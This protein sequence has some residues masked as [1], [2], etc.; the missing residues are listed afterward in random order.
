MSKDPR[1]EAERLLNA[2]SD[3]I[4]GTL[5]QPSDPRAWDTLLIYCPREAVIRRLKTLTDRDKAERWAPPLDVE[6]GLT[7][8][9][10]CVV[11]GTQTVMCC[12]DCA[13]ERNG[14]KVYVCSSRECCDKHELLHP[15]VTHL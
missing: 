2:V 3:H 8:Y 14:E 13:I 9:K 1:N 12:S 15:N 7:K 4:A 10:A 11:C 6:F 5:E